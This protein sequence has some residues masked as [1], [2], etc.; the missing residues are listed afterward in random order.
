MTNGGFAEYIALPEKNVFK[1]PNDM[2][3][4]LAASLPVSTVTP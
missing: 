1:I 2:E 3:W 4:E